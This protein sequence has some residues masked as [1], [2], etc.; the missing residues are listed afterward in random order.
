MTIHNLH[1]A[2]GLTGFKTAS[3]GFNI[4]SASTHQIEMPEHFNVDDVRKMQRDCEILAQI[5]REHPE[6]MAE[7]QNAVLNHNFHHAKKIA[8]KIGLDEDRF[9]ALGGG[10]WAAVV[11]CIMIG[12]LLFDQVTGG[13]EPE[14]AEPG[15]GSE[16]GDDD[17]DD[18]PG[19]GA[20]AD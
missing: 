11:A 6:A 18:E 4:S 9:I 15:A 19:E 20:G 17:G 8:K 2:L 10:F 5:A 14:P 7:M 13:S 3:G 1:A 16:A 12:V